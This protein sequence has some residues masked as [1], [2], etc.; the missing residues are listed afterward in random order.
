MSG[1]PEALENHAL[2]IDKMKQKKLS[3]SESL[4]KPSRFMKHH[5]RYSGQAK[6][7]ISIED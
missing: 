3:F 4:R 2:Q 6:G 5:S 7:I 1:K